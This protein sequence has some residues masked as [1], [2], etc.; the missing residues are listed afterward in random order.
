MSTMPFFIRRMD[1]KG[2]I[3]AAEVPPRAFPLVSFAYLTG[4]EILVEAEGELFH[5]TAG[6]LF[7]LPENRPFSILYYRDAHGYTGGFPASMAGEKALIAQP[8]HF[9]FWFEEAQFAGELF[10]MMARASEKNKGEF[11][12]N[13]VRL[14]LDM[15]PA[16]VCGHPGASNF[17]RQIFNPDLPFGELE[18]YAREASLTPNGFCRMIRRETGRSPGEWIAIARLTRAKHFLQETEMPVLDVAFAVGLS[19]QSYFSRFFR[20]QTGMTPLE[21]RQKMREAHK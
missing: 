2:Y 17:L 9:A 16:N 8:L 5:C 3:K 4:G 11:I 21:F 19:D 7:L 12:Q 20:K 14:L 6:H 10:N 15:L 13:A 1:T 18:D